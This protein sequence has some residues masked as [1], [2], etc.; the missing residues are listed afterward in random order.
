[1]K[2]YPKYKPTT[3]KWI[4]TIPA[5]WDCVRAQYIFN[6]VSGS[7]P[8]S[9]DE[10]LWNGN[11]NWI[12]PAD[13]NTKDHYISKGERT[14]SQKG[15]ESCSTTLVPAGSIIFSKRAPIGKVVIASEE[16][17]TNQGCFGC[18]PAKELSNNYFY[19]LIGILEPQYNLL[20]SGSTFL[21]ISAKEFS[22]FRLLF[23]SIEEQETIAEYLDEVTGKIDALVDE[24]QAQVDELRA[25][26]TSLI[27][28][29]VTR[30]LNSNAPLKDTG[31]DWLGDI[32][33]HWNTSKL[34]FY[35]DINSGVAINREEIVSDGKY[36]VYGGGERIGYTNNY[37]IDSGTII[38]GRVGA[39]CGCVK[40]V[41]EP[42]WATDNALIC[43]TS[44]N[45][46]YLST[47]LE[48]ANLNRLNESNAQPLITSTKVKNL[49]LSLPPL[50]E[51]EA[52]AD[53][54]DAKTAKIDEA[55]AELEAQLKDLANYK[56]A[57]ITEA[58]TGKVDVRDWKTKN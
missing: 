4:E 47:L 19:Y 45:P 25:Y 36:P 34:K 9:N 42:A 35:I 6:I 20:G 13:F 49:I 52:I 58:V 54:L 50:S 40:L 31:I 11:I 15:Y 2:A 38:I 41:D 22:S 3:L 27:T 56:Q 43:T 48:A 57:V 29:T 30:G 39:R 14:I 37:N 10:T 33:E 21:E 12:T 16:L 1:M 32:P 17:C 51:Q 8:N 26:R 28:E 46:K 55:I 44:L 23:P 53:F 5:H 7:T 18:I 24:K